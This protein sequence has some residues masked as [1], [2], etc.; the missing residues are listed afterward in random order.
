[1]YPKHVVAS[2]IIWNVF[3]SNPSSVARA[4]IYHKVKLSSLVIPCVHIF[5]PCMWYKFVNI[6]HDV[7]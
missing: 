1:M 6:L 3:P 5:M 7:Q 4:N 2:V